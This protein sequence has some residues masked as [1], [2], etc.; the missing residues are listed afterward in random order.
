M[1]PAVVSQRDSK[2]MM[3]DQCK[4]VRVLSCVVQEFVLKSNFNIQVVVVVV[5]D[6]LVI[7]MKK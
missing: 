6:F 3:S 4:R 7:F 5:V 1:L 2:R